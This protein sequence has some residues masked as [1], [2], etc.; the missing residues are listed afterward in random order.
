MPKRR[1]PQ[2]CYGT[3]KD[4]SIFNVLI[5]NSL[6]NAVG[7]EMYRTREVFP[8]FS[9][10]ERDIKKICPLEICANLFSSTS[11]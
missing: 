5:L 4:G 7:H 8:G 1:T 3:L 9:L 2:S 6:T 11:H 10:S